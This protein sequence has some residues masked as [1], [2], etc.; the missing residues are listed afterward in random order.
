[1]MEPNCTINAAN[2]LWTYC[3][4]FGRS[5]VAG[6]ACMCPEGASGLVLFTNNNV[7]L[8]L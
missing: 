5:F 4:N 2:T 8:S 7:P 6:A 3:F 1:L